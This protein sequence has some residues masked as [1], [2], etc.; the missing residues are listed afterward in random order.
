MKAF[1][2]REPQIRTTEDMFRCLAQRTALRPSEG[3]IGPTSPPPLVGGGGGGEIPRKPLSWAPRKDQTGHPYL[4]SGE[5]RITKNL[6]GNLWRY[7]AWKGSQRL[8]VCG[9]AEEAKR[10]CEEAR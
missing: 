3:P 9:S 1:G 8:G 2:A 6:V 5:F 7:G 4:E 10:I